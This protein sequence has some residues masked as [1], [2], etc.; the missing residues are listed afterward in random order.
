MSYPVTGDTYTRGQGEPIVVQPTLPLV[1][2]SDLVEPLAF[3][4]NLNVSGKQ[5][6]SI[7][8]SVTSFEEDGVTPAKAELRM[9]VG[10]GETQQWIP[11]YEGTVVP[12]PVTADTIEGA[13]TTGRALLKSATPAAAKTLLQLVPADVPGVLTAS[14]T[15]TATV[16][17][18]VLVTARQS[19]F[20]TASSG[21]TPSTA[22]DVAGLLVD[23]ND[24]I[25]KYNTL[26]NDV[27]SINGNLS[28]LIVATKASGQ[29]AT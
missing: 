26:R 18:P 23:L 6:G 13:G 3:I 29:M 27:N 16:K 24:L 10:S 5:L 8:V 12:A 9:A 28:A 1:N 19:G 11:L 7:V 20:S 17:G 4:N 2:N 21:D 15:A 25:G 14:S 22:T